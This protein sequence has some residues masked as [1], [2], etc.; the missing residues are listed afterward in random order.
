[1]KVICEEHFSIE[2]DTLSYLQSI[3]FLFH[4]TFYQPHKA[5]ADITKKCTFKKIE[6]S[7]RFEWLTKA[8]FL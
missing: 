2:I 3:V 7:Q 4:E 8:V 5:G 6:S 1:M